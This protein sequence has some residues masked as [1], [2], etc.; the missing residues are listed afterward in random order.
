MDTFLPFKTPL[1][2]SANL[3][4]EY[5]FTVESFLDYVNFNHIELGMV[6]DLTNTHRYYDPREFEHD[7]LLYFK[8]PCTG[9]IY[10]PSEE[11][12][13]LFIELVKKYKAT[14]PNKLVGV[15]CTH[16][17]NRTGF[18]IVSYLVKELAL[19]VEDAIEIFRQFRPPGIYRQTI[20]DELKERYG[21]ANKSPGNWV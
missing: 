20:I 1:A 4:E 16:G 19:D 21:G 3:G 11:Q 9:H 12:V 7:G 5:N 15:H 14:F 10:F 18:M 17:A 2:K 6:I 13:D 8:L